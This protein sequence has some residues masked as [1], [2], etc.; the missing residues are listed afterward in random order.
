MA[1]V[2]RFDSRQFF[3]VFLDEIGQPE[4]QPAALC[5][6]HVRQ[7]GKARFAAATALSISATWAMATCVISEL[8]WGFRTVM[9][10]PSSASTNSR[11]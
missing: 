7:A 8:S 3:G 1:G 2:D 5:G 10:D 11:Q 4:Q 9:V 6:L